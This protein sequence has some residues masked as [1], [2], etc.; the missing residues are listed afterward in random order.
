MTD[1]ALRDMIPSMTKA[2]CLLLALISCCAIAGTSDRVVA[3][4]DGDTL[5]VLRADRQQLK[6]RLVEIDAP[7][8]GQAFGNRSKQSL[9]D[10]CF[11]KA[12]RLE[13]QGKD[14]YQRTLA[15]VYCDEVDANSEQVR[16]GMAWI[17]TRY[18]PKD[19]PLY[20]VEAEA[21]TARRGLWADAEPVP[22]WEWRRSKA[23]R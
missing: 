22:P 2:A 18:A 21:R 9:S 8:T 3:V 17:F 20:A 7:E 23:A 4:A 13:E 19:S 12:A 15:R 16:R 11:G 10:I 6:V 14:R 1:K 5:T